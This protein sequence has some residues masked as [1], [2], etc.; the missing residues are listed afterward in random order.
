MNNE[1]L[2]LLWERERAEF[3]IASLT[4]PNCGDKLERT[5]A[6]AFRHANDVPCDY[7]Q[8]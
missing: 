8:Q 6:G 7:I 4:C 3:A 1:K 5:P 2:R